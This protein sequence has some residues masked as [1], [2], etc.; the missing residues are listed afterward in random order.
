MFQV[1]DSVIYGAHG[2]CRI[3]AREIRRVDRKN[4]TY[5]VLEPLDKDGS[6]YYVPAQNEAAMSKLR[7]VL[8][9][10]KLE[11]LIYSERIREDGWIRDENQRKHRYKELI[12]SGDR[13]GLLRAIHS[14]YRQRETLTA[15][16]RKIHLCDDNFLRDAEKML[17]GEIAF[18]LDMTQAEARDFLRVKLNGKNEQ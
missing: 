15:V 8:S 18:T 1:G 6:R 10:Q 12:V 2:V 17:T 11:D 13:E 7:S 4:L 9:R 5:L 14:I 3:A 16:G